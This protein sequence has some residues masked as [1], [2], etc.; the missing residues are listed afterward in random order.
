MLARIIRG[1]KMQ[2]LHVKVFDVTKPTKGIKN[3]A[4]LFRV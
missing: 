2:A 3:Y 4:E 1:N